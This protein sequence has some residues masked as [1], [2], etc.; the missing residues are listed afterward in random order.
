M[1]GYEQ[2]VDSQ[3]NQQYNDDVEMSPNTNL[4]EN[5]IMVLEPLDEQN[6]PNLTVPNPSINLSQ[7]LNDNGGEQENNENNIRV[8][9]NEVQNNDINVYTNPEV[10]EPNSNGNE[11]KEENDKLYF[12]PELAKVEVNKTNNSY[13]YTEHQD[14]EFSETESN[15]FFINV[16]GGTMENT[17]GN[18]D[19]S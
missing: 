17:N 13:Q 18:N 2:F 9:L 6:P 19:N 12:Y 8:E 1:E 4:N 16:T 14:S 5:N 11:D 3:N 7:L 15:V 10:Y